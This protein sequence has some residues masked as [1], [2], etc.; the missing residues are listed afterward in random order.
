MPSRYSTAWVGPTEYSLSRTD[1][2]E[3][4]FRHHLKA[5]LGD[6]DPRVID[7][8]AAHRRVIAFDNRGVGAPGGS[9]PSTITW[10]G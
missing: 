9:L 10:L 3:S 8:V 7:G 2:A 4:V 6:R 5:V 1:G